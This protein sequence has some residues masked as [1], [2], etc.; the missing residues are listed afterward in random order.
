MGDNSADQD[1]RVEEI[2]RDLESWRELSKQDLNPNV[3]R[4]LERQI[5]EAEDRL[6]DIEE[7]NS[8]L[9]Q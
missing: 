7:G 8:S 2:L 4:N 9:Q 6:R 5:R 3:R 1:K